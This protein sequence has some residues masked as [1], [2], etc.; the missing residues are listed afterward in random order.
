MIGPLLG[1]GISAWLGVRMV[2]GTAA[3]LYLAAGLLALR[4]LPR[5]NHRI[6]GDK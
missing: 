1:V 2:F 4:G 6:G 5:G 3:L